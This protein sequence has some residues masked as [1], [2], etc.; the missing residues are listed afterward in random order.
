MPRRP[1]IHLAGVPQHVIQRGVDR[2]PI[3]FSDDDCRF[4]LDLLGKYASKRS[5]LLHSY[6]LMTNHFHLVL[7]SP[8]GE[9]LSCLMQDIGRRYVQYI[10][11]TYQRTGGLWQGR[12]KTSYIQSEVY[13]LSCMRYVELNPVHAGMVQT[14]GDYRWSSYRANAFGDE[15]LLVNP[16][17]E[18]LALGDTPEERHQGYQTL[19]ITE[20]DDSAWSL[21]Q[22]ATQQGAVAG[23]SRFAEQIE[24][25]LGKKVQLRPQGRPHK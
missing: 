18:Y 23:D 20:A 17:E 25:S 14:P 11:Q 3:F 13:L 12:Y 8:T 16:H 9:A 21:I 1:R 2:Q 7:S 4:F 15:N 22:T 6:C 24:Q 5:V 10:N 19:F